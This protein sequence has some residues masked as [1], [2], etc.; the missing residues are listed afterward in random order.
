MTSK[1][2]GQVKWNP[3]PSRLI[4]E[5]ESVHVWRVSLTQPLSK[6]QAFWH[7]FTSDEKRRAAAFFF[8]KDRERFIACRGALRIILSRYLRTT[9][10]QIRF[11][12]GQYGKPALI[13]AVNIQGLR[14]NVSHSAQIA[15]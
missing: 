13:E 4:L 3:P 14:F 12:Y 9:P 10:D 15:L 2:L 1:P 11:H 5:G 6:I 7:L 8:R